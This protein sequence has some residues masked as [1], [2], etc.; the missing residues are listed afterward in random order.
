M[1]A[2]TL[3]SLLKVGVWVWFYYGRDDDDDDDGMV[4]FLTPSNELLTTNG[5]ILDIDYH[6]M[7][8]GGKA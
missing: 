6:I 1:T 8:V 4:F 7:L 3:P 2:Q 5:C